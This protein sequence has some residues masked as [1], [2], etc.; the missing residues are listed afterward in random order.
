LL[1]PPLIIFG[2]GG[3]GHVVLD[4]ALVSGRNVLYVLDDS[5]KVTEIYGI[6]VIASHESFWIPSAPWEFVIAIGEN[7]TRA[8]VIECL[9]TLGGTLSS[10]MHS[11]SIVSKR[12]RL[13]Q[14]CVLLAGSI[15]NPEAHVGSNVILNTGSTVDH[16]CRIG[17]HVHVCPGVHL[18]GN[19]VIGNYSTI[20]TGAVIKPGV[21]IGRNCIVGAGA[22]VVSDLP[23]NSVCTGVPAKVI[24]YLE[25][26]YPE[27]QDEQ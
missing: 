2:S 12:C 4:A 11:S 19:V 24:R 13:G 22:V 1:N 6:S 10:V 8:K 17:N 7:H 5:P 3:H 23:D 21:S 18:A 25:K 20:G 26:D 14:G 16:H 27:N 9:K 15:V